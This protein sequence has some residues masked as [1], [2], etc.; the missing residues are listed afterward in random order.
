MQTGLAKIMNLLK[1]QEPQKTL[2]NLLAHTYI[3]Q[4]RESP[5]GEW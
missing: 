2:T 5:R 1:D 3:A 4:I